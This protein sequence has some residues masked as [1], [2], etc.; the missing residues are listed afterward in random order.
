MALLAGAGALAVW[1][2]GALSFVN[3]LAWAADNPVRRLMIGQAVGAERMGA[4]MSVDVGTNN[5][6]RLLGPTL[7]GAILAGVGIGGAFWV[8]VALYAAALVAALAVRRRATAPRAASG[9][10]VL[11]RDRRGL[12]ASCGGTAGWPAPSS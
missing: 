3:G 11:A 8:S 7:G 2:L 6:S 1:H 10:G 9:E 12:R 5:A 4:A